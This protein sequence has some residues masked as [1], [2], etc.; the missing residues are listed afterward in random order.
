MMLKKKFQVMQSIFGPGFYHNIDLDVPMPEIEGASL[1]ERSL[2]RDQLRKTIEE[3]LDAVF[4]HALQNVE[5]EHLSITPLGADVDFDGPTERLVR[6]YEEDLG[7]VMLSG[8]VLD[9]TKKALSAF[10]REET[11]RGRERDYFQLTEPE[12]LFFKLEN[13][14]YSWATSNSVAPV[15]T[16]LDVN[17]QSRNFRNI[18]TI[19]NGFPHIYTKPGD[20][21]RSIIQINPTE[22]EIYLATVFYLGEPNEQLG[23]TY[24]SIHETNSREY[25]ETHRKLGFKVETLPE[26]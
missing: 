13:G 22:P 19:G 20:A 5:E 26:V 8:D 4:E 16:C 17:L 6:N 15:I 25:A 23:E 7:R 12:E 10:N 11:Y 9:I 24:I 3:N 2:K 14:H 1:E 21:F 18:L